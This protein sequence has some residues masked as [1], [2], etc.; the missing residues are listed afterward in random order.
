MVCGEDFACDAHDWIAFFKLIFL[1]LATA[2]NFTGWKI[3]EILEK[4]GEK[5][6]TLLSLSFGLVRWWRYREHVLYKRL[7]EY[8]RESDRRL[9]P[10]SKGVVAAL[11]RQGNTVPLTQP[12]FA[13]ELRRVLDDHGWRSWFWFSGV[14][15]QAERQIGSI[16][17]GIRKRERILE[18]AQ[19]SID[20]QKV[21]AHLLAGAV[22]AA[23]AR[24]ADGNQNANRRND[25]R[26]LREF[27]EV[28]R[29]PR[30]DRNIVAKEWEAYQ[31][32]RL[33]N[34]QLATEAYIEL[35]NLAKKG[36]LE[37]RAR[38]L[39]IASAWRYR[40]QILQIQADTAGSLAAWYFIAR[41]GQQPTAINLRARHY[42][43]TKWEKIEQA[44]THYVAAH[45][46]HMLD[47]VIEEPSHLDRAA[48]QYKDAIE[49]VARINLFMSKGDQELRDEAQRGLARIEAARNGQ[50][51]H[52]WLSC[53]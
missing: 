29:S 6:V 36:D 34:L 40:A 38:D 41:S 45:I 22:Y 8:V 31:F 4:H 43:F 7:E 16:M 15:R 46:A 39:T 20:E 51:D 11:L 26:A 18:K 3:I 24:T 23:R 14:E 28:L 17:S 2:W 9:A 35:E 49:H 27:Q 19:V 10:A 52:T 21:Q 1:Q 53:R 44:E 42:P 32:L 50:Y 30:H 25:H 12:A 48:D 33:G 13:I 47:Y 37:A 5:L